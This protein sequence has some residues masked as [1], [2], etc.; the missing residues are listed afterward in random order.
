MSNNKFYMYILKCS[1]G[2]YYVGHTDDITKRI[3]E[4]Q[5]GVLPCY[6][7]NRRPVKLVYLQDF[8]TRNEA[9]AAERKVKKWNRKKKEALIAGNWNLLSKLS[10]RKKKNEPAQILRDDCF[11]IPPRLRTRLRRTSQ[12]ERVEN[13]FRNTPKIK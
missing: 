5:M 7:K 13:K 3:S 10:K 1:D 2:S 12:D 11:A 9:F 4:H 8:A 6:T